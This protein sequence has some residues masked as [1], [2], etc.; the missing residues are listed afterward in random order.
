MNNYI[1]EMKALGVQIS[2]EIIVNVREKIDKYQNIL[3]MIGEK[4][5]SPEEILRLLCTCEISFVSQLFSRILFLYSTDSKKEEDLKIIILKA[6][7]ISLLNIK[8]KH[9]ETIHD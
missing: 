8:N 2:N 1:E 5:I 6:I 4:S 3:E 9:K 7:D